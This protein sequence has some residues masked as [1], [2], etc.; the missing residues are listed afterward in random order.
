MAK[1]TIT[2]DAVTVTSAMKL[3]DLKTIEKY[4]PKAMTLMGG[5]DGKEPIFR[6]CTTNGSGDINAYGAAFSGETRDD[7][8]LAY[9]TMFIG[10]DVA[11][12][13]KEF[14][15]D[16]IGGAIINL[17]KLE[18]QLPAVLAEI[19]AEKATVMENITVAQ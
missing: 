9:V 4:R 7:A 11:G 2:G 5:E 12:D 16:K 14:I 15:A 1:I 13:I 10:S 19:A 17:N 18:E 6:V 8:K 3:E